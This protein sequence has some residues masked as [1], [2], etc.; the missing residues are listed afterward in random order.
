MLNRRTWIERLGG[1]AA[2]AVA[3]VR[4][5][6]AGRAISPAAGWYNVKD[7]GAKGDG[8]SDDTTALQ[9]AIGAAGASGQGL[10]F[11]GGTYR[12]TAPL[13]CSSAG[14]KLIGVGYLASTIEKHHS[15]DA[16]VVTRGA[17]FEVHGLGIRGGTQVDPRFGTSGRGIYFNGST[18]DAKILSSAIT[19][20]DVGIECS[21]D[22]AKRLQVS[23]CFIDPLTTTPGA[24]G[25]LVWCHGPD[26]GA[27]QRSFVN[28][29]GNGVMRFDGALDV[30]LVAST[31][32]RAEI[33]ATS[34]AVLVI[35]CI[36]GSLDK[37]MTID[38][39]TVLIMGCR[40]AGPVTL[41]TT[42]TGAFI[43]NAQTA[44]AFT[45]HSGALV[46][47]YPLAMS[48]AQLGRHTFT[49][50]TPAAGVLAA[51]SVS[52]DRG[53]AS[54]TLTP[55]V[56]ETVQLF[57][58]PLTQNR[59]VTVSTTGARNGQRFRIV[60]TGLG[61][62]TLAVDSLKT[63]PADTAAFVEV[64]FTGSRWILTGYGTL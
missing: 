21:P 60:R 12:T 4:P 41:A 34:F 33:D 9:Q 5:T 23:D 44:G 57:A 7:Y 24:E 42:L 37:P 3:G 53:D 35:G 15:G 30:C 63:I 61:N 17:G 40:F 10:F 28:V 54:V 1:W 56:S 62:F 39:R 27:T 52:A 51:E 6:A 29:V 11:P 55:D 22:S 49:A 25:R 46:L 8:R 50:G 58:T 16:I 32:R 2:L 64:M 19:Q 18:D 31:F 13:I 26:T 36:W 43:G 38:G 20:I 14:L 48:Y 59:T 45:N 47:H